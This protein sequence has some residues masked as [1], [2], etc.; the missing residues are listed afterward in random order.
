MSTV[1]LT[2]PDPTTGHRITTDLA[3]ELDTNLF[4]GTGAEIDTGVD[5]SRANAGNS[6]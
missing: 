6:G 5:A 1:H 2:A 3:A 4:V